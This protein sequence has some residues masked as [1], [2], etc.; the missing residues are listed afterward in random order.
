MGALIPPSII[1]QIRSANDIVEVIGG[2]LR[3]KRSGAGFFALCPFHK[4]KT[5]SFYVN[6]QR[7]IFHCFGCHKGGNVFTFIMEYENVNFV[8]AVKMLAERAHIQ[9]QF[10]NIPIQEKQEKELLYDIH[11]Q[12]TRRWHSC[13]LNEA[14]GA[15]ARDYLKKRGVSE[16]AIKI[17]RLGYAPESWDD[18]L[19]WGTSKGYPPDILEKAGLIVR[20]DEFKTS[21]ARAS[22]N[23]YDRFRGRLIFP[24]CDEQGRVVAFSGRILNENEKTAKYLNSPETAIFRK[25]K[26][27]Y[28][29]DK[30]KK[31]ILD[32]GCAIVCEGQLDL[33]SCYMN[34]IKNV[35]APQGTAFTDEHCRILKRYTDEVVLCFDSDNAGQEAAIRAAPILFSYDI[36][37]KVAIIPEPDDPDSFI[38]KFGSQKF[39]ELINNAR[40]F[41]DFYLDRLCNLH[42]P[43]T[44][45]GKIMV[46]REFGS[47]LKKI[48]NATIIDSYKTKLAARLGVAKAAVD[49]EFKK[50]TIQPQSKTN[51]E[52]LAKDA[53][54]ISKDELWLLKIVFSKPTTI[55]ILNDYLDVNW[56]QDT[57][58]QTIIEKL[59]QQKPET[60]DV[61]RFIEEFENVEQMAIISESAIKPDAIPNPEKQISD[62]IKKLRNKFIKQQ[63][64]R[65][66]MQLSQN[67]LDD[68]TIL[69]LLKNISE[70]KK[71]QEEPLFK[72]GE[73]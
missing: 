9:I 4:E 54:P 45:K 60:F 36:A 46:T 50:I 23:F 28:G 2:Y 24:I 11:E 62:L 65:L 3:L 20:R 32:A 21:T 57:R 63:I 67:N 15:V 69:N 43:Q 68:N 40:Q 66:K 17:F 55:E 58:I 71:A 22:D 33:I 61:S 19:N 31:A 56:I 44:D 5:P 10:E 7:Q 52:E 16:E 1:E 12:I 6:P 48:Q 70:L 42:D 59:M 37:V 64:D 38:K 26:I 8:E 14:A 27:F 35:V 13:L 73:I 39:Q 49:E 29:L 25:S 47:A 72:K 53:T 41:F 18:T 34:G 30:S 51:D